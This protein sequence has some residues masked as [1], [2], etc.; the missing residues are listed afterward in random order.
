MKTQLTHIRI[1]VSD[2]NKSLKWYEEVLGFENDGGWPLDKPTY[3]DFI[4]GTGATF[5]IMEVKTEKSY[6]R[7]NFHCE[8]VDGLWNQL[9]DRVTVVEPLFNTSY[10]TRKFTIADPDGN[11]LGFCMTA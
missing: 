4:T 7:L 10:G 2:I 3:Y 6:G 8:D 11:E 9:K 5:A 1:N